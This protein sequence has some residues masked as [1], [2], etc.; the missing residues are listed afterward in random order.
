VNLDRTRA[1]KQLERI[2][3]FMI[4]QT[5]EICPADKKLYALR[6]VT[7]TVPSQ[8]LIVASIMCKKLAENLDRLVL[9][10][11]F[12]KGA[13]MKTRDKAEL[14]GEALLRVWRRNGHA[15]LISAH[16]DGRATGS[17]GR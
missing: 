3:V 8:P 15:N 13:F 16:G 11:R 14:L 4:G 7:G 17:H 9:N 1:I 5:A 12:G 10:V 6:D 2:G